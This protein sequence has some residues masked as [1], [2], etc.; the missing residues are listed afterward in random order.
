M[1]ENDTRLGVVA[2]GYGDGYPRAA[3]SGTP[4]LVNGREVKIVGRVAM[5]MICVDL[6]PDADDKAVMQSC[7]GAKVSPLSALLKLRK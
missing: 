5:D 7:C 6:G 2:M 4:V 3:P 1:S